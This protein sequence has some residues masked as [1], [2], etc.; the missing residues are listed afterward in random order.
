VENDA[1]GMP[2]L[3]TNSADFM[4]HTCPIGSFGTW[5]GP[6]VD[7]EYAAVSMTDGNDLETR[8]HVWSLLSQNK[9]TVGKAPPW[10]ID[11]EGNLE[12]KREGTIEV[13]MQAIV[14]SG[15]VF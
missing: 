10:C 13:A 11:Q 15:T 1:E 2:R 12:W 6:M 9:F 8:L 5:D 7:R 3:G 4:P 14:V